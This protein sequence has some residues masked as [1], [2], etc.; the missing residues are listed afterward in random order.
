MAFWE[1]LKDISER[2]T[3]TES[4][5]EDLGDLRRAVLPLGPGEREGGPAEV[6]RGEQD[7]DGQ[8]DLGAEAVDAHG[9]EVREHAQQPAVQVA[10]RQASPAGLPSP[11]SY[12]SLPAIKPGTSTFAG[13]K[14]SLARTK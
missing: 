3:G 6:D 12:S 11:D 4:V 14:P 10:E 8:A 2:F 13:S 7:R 5:A 1:R 9:V